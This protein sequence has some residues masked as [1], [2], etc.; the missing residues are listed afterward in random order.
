MAQPRGGWRALLLWL[1]AA[2]PVLATAGVLCFFVSELAGHT[3]LSDGPPANIAEAA[4]L[5]SAAELLRMLREGHDPHVIL[6]VRPE[7]ISSTVTRVTGLE[8][9]V[10]SR[11]AQLIDVLNRYGALADPEDFRHAF[12]LA[13]DVGVD[14]IVNYLAKS[15]T[16]AC[17]NGAVLAAVQARTR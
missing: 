1:A 3:F 13:R 12:C 7:I 15:G 6:P 14:E 8:A 16:P 9:A 17:E 11:K 10:W 4:G 2:P 5:G